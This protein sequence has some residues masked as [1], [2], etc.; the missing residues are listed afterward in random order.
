MT[1]LKEAANGKETLRD[2]IHRAAEKMDLPEG[3]LCGLPQVTLDGDLQLLIERHQGITEYGTQRILITSQ[4]FTIEVC[5]DDMY[6]VS[7]DREN[8]RIRGR[9]FGVRYLRE[10]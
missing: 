8:I 3:M 5:G 6:L 2:K 1:C 4:R 10:E 9:I 7:M